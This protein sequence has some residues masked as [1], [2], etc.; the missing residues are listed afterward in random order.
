MLALNIVNKLLANYLLP[1]FLLYLAPNTS[2]YCS[3]N[4]TLIANVM[5][6]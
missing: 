4:F 6:A 1:F 5:S 2:N 3:K